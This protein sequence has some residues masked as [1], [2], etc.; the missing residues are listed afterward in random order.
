M[1][2]LLNLGAGS[3]HNS[4]ASCGVSL[5]DTVSAVNDSIGGKIGALD[6]FHKLSDGA[7]GVIHSV[8]SR[9]DDLSKVV[10]RDVGRHTDGDTHRAV[11]QKIGE[12]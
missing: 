1:L 12:S 9:V 6:V 8:D 7:L 11:Y 5:N 2:I 4:A 10:G 3:D